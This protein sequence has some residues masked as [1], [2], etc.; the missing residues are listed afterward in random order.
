MRSILLLTLLAGSVAAQ[1]RPQE[2]IPIRKETKREAAAAVA[3]PAAPIVIHDT[4]VV[5]RTDTL[6]VFESAVASPLADT[7]VPATCRSLF[8]PIPIPIPFS[9]SGGNGAAAA[10]VATT[11]TPEPGSLTL[12]GTGLLGLTLYVKKHRK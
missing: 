2:R 6:G 8:V 9:H 4:V 11:A 5:Y 1:A 10:A 7:G 12:L 3:P